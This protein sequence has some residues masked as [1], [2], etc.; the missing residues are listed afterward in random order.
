MAQAIANQRGIVTAITAILGVL[1]GFGVIKA[2][3]Q[4]AILGVVGIVF[5]WLAGSAYVQGKHVEAAALLASK[6][7]TPSAMTPTGGQ[8][9]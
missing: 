2:S 7:P 9:G 8:A 5:S 3:D 1:V 4:T 6:A